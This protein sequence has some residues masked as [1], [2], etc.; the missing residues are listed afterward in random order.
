LPEKIKNLIF[1]NPKNIGYEKNFYDN[2]RP[3]KWSYI[4][5]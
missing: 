3:G 1:Y 2:A 5:R 4:H